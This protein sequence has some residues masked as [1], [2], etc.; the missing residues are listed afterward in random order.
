MP[1]RVQQFRSHLMRYQYTISH[2]AGKDLCT[3]DTLSSALTNVVDKQY[4][5]FQQELA[6]YVNL[7][8]DQL[9]A[10]KTGIQ[11]IRKEQEQD[12]V[13]QKLMSYCQTGWPDKSRLQGLYKAYA[14]V[15]YE[16]SVVQ[17]VLLRGYHI[18]IPSKMQTN[19]IE[20]LHAGHQCISK[21]RRQA[22]QSLWWPGLG[23][24]LKERISHM[25]QY[26]SVQVKPLMPTEM[27]NHPW[28]RVATDLFKWQKLQYL[29]V[30]DYY[31]WYTEG[32]KLGSTSS[33]TVIKHLKSIFALH[34]IP[35]VVMSDNG[36]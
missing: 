17:G 12:P 19:I 16:L 27:S 31:S 4:N 22:Q 1:L 25:S 10:T 26:R 13:C 6:S 5:Q 24:T 9:L 11:E 34:G 23:K 28:E 29:I 36:P 32:A 35:K 30:V 33:P 14:T 15:K 7:I 8:V 3:A 18:V 20:K 2:I 21:C